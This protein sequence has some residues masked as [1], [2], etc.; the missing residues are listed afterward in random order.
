MVF[1]AKNQVISTVMGLLTCFLLAGTVHANTEAGLASGA[2]EPIISSWYFNQSIAKERAVI[3]DFNDKFIL[4]IPASALKDRTNLVL[5]DFTSYNISALSERQSLISDVLEFDF[6]NKQAF[7]GKKPLTL[8]IKINQNTSDLKIIYYFDKGKNAWHPLSSSYDSKKG[9]IK[10][11]IFLPYARVAV[12]SH[13]DIL[14]EGHATWYK[15]KNCN[16]AASPDYPKGTLLTVTNLGNNKSL[17]VKVNDF[18]PDRALYPDRVI[19]LD[20]TA[21]S[22]IGNLKNG[23][24]DVLVEP[25]DASKV[26][27]VYRDRELTVG[28]EA[29]IIINAKDGTIL[30]AKNPDQLAPIASLT[31]LM[32]ASVFLDAGIPWGQAITYE[33]AYNVNGNSVKIK[34]GD[35]ITAQD[36]FFAALVESSNNMAK[37]L[38]G[39]TGLT[40]D[41]FVNKMNEK[42]RDWGLVATN[43]VEPTGLDPKNRSTAKEYAQLAL[44]ALNNVEI[45]RGT[46]TESYTVKVNDKPSQ[47]I[48]NTNQLLNTDLEITGGKTGYTNDA[49]YCLISK[50]KNQDTNDE[51]LALVLGEPDS[52]RRFADVEKMLRW[53]LAKLA[54]NNLAQKPTNFLSRTSN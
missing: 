49:G 9:T 1:S 45:L 15:Y 39:A 6:I 22:K 54:E 20:K 34:P 16:C 17:V 19:D 4:S 26:A 40:E 24:I 10:A 50:V 36:L 21:F 47:T 42:A 14:G 8:E 44:K 31:K 38:S 18:G 51:V 25:L 48:K 13:Q 3:S 30:W 33:K 12:F 32:T 52:A 2:D 23:V 41:E 37:A 29:A 27:Q 35:K 53:G 7:T 11:I 5:K 43:F 46:T 28:A